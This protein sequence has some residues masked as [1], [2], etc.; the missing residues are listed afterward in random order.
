MVLTNITFDDVTSLCPL[1]EDSPY[2]LFFDGVSRVNPGPGGAGAIILMCSVSPASAR[3]RWM[4]S[5]SLANR[6]T[7]N[8]T[9]EYEAL[10]FGFRKA[11]EYHLQRL[12][13][14]SDS[15]LIMGQLRRRRPPK[16][17]RLFDLYRQF[18]LLGDRLGVITWIHHLRQYNRM[19]D[20]LTNVAKDSRRSF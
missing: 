20:A 3:I 2:V 11:H 7:T 12:H 8:N 15:E 13:V 4:C 19:A 6:T 16:T 9:A 5:V 14:V 17:P 1:A 10:L 18:R